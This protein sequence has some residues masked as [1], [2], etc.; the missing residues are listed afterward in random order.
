MKEKT[1]FYLFIL[2]MLC[3]SCK[4]KKTYVVEGQI[5]GVENSLIALVTYV[6]DDIRI[7][8]VYAEDGK[9]TYTSSFY[10]TIS[11]IEINM[12][13]GDVWITAWVKNG[14]K[15]KISGNVDNPELVEIKGNEV[16]E[17]LTKFR[18]NNKKIIEEKNDLEDKIKCLQTA[19]ND[20]GYLITS[21]SYFSQKNAL[22]QSLMIKAS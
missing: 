9:F 6:G 22:E 5:E 7:D 19:E 10:D 16:N 8:S 15:I 1:V 14:E 17:L 12:K 21:E 13:Q 20:S 11:P 4:D 18:Q 2:M 3:S